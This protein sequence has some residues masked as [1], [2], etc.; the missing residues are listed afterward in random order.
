M[1]GVRKTTAKRDT[2]TGS[3][4]IC[5]DP[6][7]V[8]TFP[9]LGPTHA[10]LIHSS[11]KSPCISI[12][13]CR[14]RRGA[15][16]ADHAGRAF[17]LGKGITS[18]AAPPRTLAVPAPPRIGTPVG[19]IR[20]QRHRGRMHAA[21]EQEQRKN[22]DGHRPPWEIGTPD[23]AHLRCRPAAGGPQARATRLRLPPGDS[24]RLDQ[25]QAGTATR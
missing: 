25:A 11:P 16:L 23:G 2:Q 18:R 19:T 21:D 9:R 3:E 12:A 24:R 7:E 4:Q 13:S 10:S 17:G 1:G 5:S 15:G 8:S 6:I 22:P 14:H 20:V